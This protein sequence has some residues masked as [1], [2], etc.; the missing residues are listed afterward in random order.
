MTINQGTGDAGAERRRRGSDYRMSHA[1]YTEGVP[2]SRE[3]HVGMFTFHTYS[4]PLLFIVASSHLPSVGISDV[5]GRFFS[6]LSRLDRTL[7]AVMYW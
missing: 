3:K 1:K 7:V 4:S 6:S 5:L 2:A